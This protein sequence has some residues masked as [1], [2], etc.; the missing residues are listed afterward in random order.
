M[1]YQIDLTL[2]QIGLHRLVS[3]D[4][5]RT[6]LQYILLRKGTLYA[7]DGLV[8]AKSS[9]IDILDTE[10]GKLTKTHDDIFFPAP[11]FAVLEKIAKSL[12]D[13]ITITIKHEQAHTAD[14]GSQYT[15]NLPNTQINGPYPDVAFL[16]EHITQAHTKGATKANIFHAPA[17]PLKTLLSYTNAVAPKEIITFILTEPEEH[18]YGEIVWR[19]LTNQEIQGILIGYPEPLND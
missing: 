5:R 17:K 4:P 14:I 12:K 6:P 15:W 8:F 18:Y 16:E 7:T 2:K 10:S 13:D 1:A 9:F 11:M 3:K 19:F